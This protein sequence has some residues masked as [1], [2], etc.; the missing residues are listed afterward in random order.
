MPRVLQFGCVGLLCLSLLGCVRQFPRWP[1]VG[2]DGKRWEPFHNKLTVWLAVEPG[3]CFGCLGSAVMAV[4]ELLQSRPG[5]VA[6]VILVVGTKEPG[7]K[8]QLPPESYL[9]KVTPEA[10]RRSFGGFELPFLAVCNRKGIL[11]RAETLPPSG[12][13]LCQLEHYFLE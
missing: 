5:E 7:W 1:V 13:T 4:R 8:T 3:A 9:V 6:V 12:G 2:H 11:V 10:F